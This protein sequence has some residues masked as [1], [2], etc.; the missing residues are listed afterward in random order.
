MRGLAIL[1]ARG[2]TLE[3]V[4]RYRGLEPPRSEAEAWRA[5]LAD[6]RARGIPVTMEEQQEADAATD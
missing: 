6:R 2:V 4:A 1:A 5:I 3:A